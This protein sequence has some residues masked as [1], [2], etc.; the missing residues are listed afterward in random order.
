M[1]LSHPGSRV[2][3]RMGPAQ[4]D[5]LVAD[6]IIFYYSSVVAVVT[7]DFALLLPF[8]LLLSLLSAFLGCLRSYNCCIDI[9]L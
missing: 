2:R 1:S 7:V 8:S 3:P 6:V 4:S 9:N 5:G